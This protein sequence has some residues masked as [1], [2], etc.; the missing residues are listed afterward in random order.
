MNRD[1][2][3]TCA[4]ISIVKVTVSTPAAGARDSAGAKPKTAQRGQRDPDRSIASHL[5]PAD[6][7]PEAAHFTGAEV[8]IEIS[9]PKDRQIRVVDDIAA[10]NCTAA[11]AVVIGENREGW[12][13]RSGAG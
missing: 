13:V 7:R 5:L 6:K 2:G 8:A 9:T 3:F 10:N 4:E 11:A 12:R 1:I